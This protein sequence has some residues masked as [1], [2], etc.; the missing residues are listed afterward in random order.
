LYSEI[1]KLN[2]KELIDTY[3]QLIILYLKNYSH[4]NIILEKNRIKLVEKI[5]KEKHDFISKSFPPSISFIIE[6]SLNSKLKSIDKKNK[7]H[8]DQM[9]NKI[10]KK[11][12][13]VMCNFGIL[14]VDFVCMTCS[15]K[16]CIK[17]ETKIL[18]DK[19]VCKKEDIE[20]LEEIEK[21]VKCP[22][23]K[24][25]VVKSYGCHHMT[26]SICKTNFDF[27][28]GKI[29]GAGNHS[30]DTLVL[31]TDRK[32][33]ILLSEKKEYDIQAINLLRKIENKE[34]E[35][36]SFNNIISFLK[37]YIDAEEKKDYK[38]LD[39]LITQ[40][41][42]TYETYKQR[43]HEKEKYLKHIFTIKDLHDKNQLTNEFLEK[44]NDIIE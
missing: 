1:Q 26:C 20:S 34:P 39:K 15:D 37:K 38:S 24:L 42:K 16:F 41:S 44:I 12:P 43:K 32:I 13:N 40:I 21:L 5:R 8:I 36:Y 33:S 18:D 3:E 14:D 22:T 28:S 7:K 4:D 30:N 29:G 23:C 6:T 27:V 9:V 31:K 35:N 19:H 2:N 17:C 10:N 25:P 11:C